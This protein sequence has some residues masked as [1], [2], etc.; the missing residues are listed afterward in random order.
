VLLVSDEEKSLEKIME[1]IPFQYM[2]RMRRVR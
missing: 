2:R 1:K